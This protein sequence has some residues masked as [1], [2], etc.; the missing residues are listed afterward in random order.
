MPDVYKRQVVDNADHA[1]EIRRRIGVIRIVGQ[2]LD[3]VGQVRQIRNHR[4]IQRLKHIF[5][6]HPLDHV[7][8]RHQHVIL[9]A[10]QQDVYKRQPLF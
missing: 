8:G 3:A 10:A 4:L 5:V 1:P 7:I 6:D 2:T 9:T